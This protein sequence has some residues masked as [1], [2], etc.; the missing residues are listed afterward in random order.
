MWHMHHCTGGTGITG[1]TSLFDGRGVLAFWGKPIGVPDA[2]LDTWCHYCCQKEKINPPAF[3]HYPSC[4]MLLK[5]SKKLLVL[6]STF[7]SPLF[8][9]KKLVNS[10]GFVSGLTTLIGSTRWWGDSG[11]SERDARNCIFPMSTRHRQCNN[12]ATMQQCNHATVPQCQCYRV[13]GWNVF[14]EQSFAGSVHIYKAWKI[15]SSVI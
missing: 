15:F 9:L 3:F 2:A 8:I 14:T 10:S 6:Y 1:D 5:A 11:S 13:P 12:S 4:P 7:A